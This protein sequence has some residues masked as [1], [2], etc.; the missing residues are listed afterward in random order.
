MKRK[1]EEEGGEGE[2]MYK[3]KNKWQ[4]YIQYINNIKS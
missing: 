4:T 3:N 1:A 2:K